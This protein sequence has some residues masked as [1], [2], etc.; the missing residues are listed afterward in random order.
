MLFRSCAE[1][2][3]L[4]RVLCEL[5]PNEPENLGLLGL[6]LLQDSRRTARVN[7]CGELVVL[8]EQ[9]RSIWDR[10]KI[11]E[12]IGLV[13]QALRMGRAGNYQ[14]QAAVGAVHAEAQTATETDWPQIVALYEEL[15]RLNGSPIVA[16]N[17]AVAVAMSGEITCALGLMDQANAARKL[18][19]YYLYHAARADLLRR[20]GRK[21][22]AA[23]VY[24]RAIA[25]ATNRVEQEYLRRRL[26]EVTET[27]PE[28]Q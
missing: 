3:R 24:Q 12:G 6:M 10:H 4:T 22:D 21:T 14:L 17:H 20:L 5:I 1:A 28:R 2:I 18:E 15:M 23:A 9:D 8:E 7:N 13:E 25:L 27:K 19:H 16:L 26:R 11:A